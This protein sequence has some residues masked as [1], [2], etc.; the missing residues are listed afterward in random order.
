MSNNLGM[1][2]LCYMHQLSTIKPCEIPQ[3]SRFLFPQ[4][5]EEA[6]MIGKVH[7]ISGD[8]TQMLTQDLKVRPF[9]MLYACKLCLTRSQC[10]V[11]ARQLLKDLKADVDDKRARDAAARQ[12]RGITEVPVVKDTVAEVADEKR[13]DDAGG[14]VVDDDLETECL[15]PS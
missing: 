15:S 8:H 5:H 3:C 10:T 4:N 11:R 9:G 6:E 14:F 7:W 13:D 2:R 1:R 12:V